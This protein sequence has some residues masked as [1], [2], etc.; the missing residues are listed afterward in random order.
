[1]T[2][3]KGKGRHLSPRNAVTSAFIAVD[4]IVVLFSIEAHFHKLDPAGSSIRSDHLV[5]ETR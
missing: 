5:V 2:Q 1:M 3:K 4:A